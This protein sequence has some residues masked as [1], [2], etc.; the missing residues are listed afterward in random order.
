[1]TAVIHFDPA[2]IHPVIDGVWHRVRIGAIPRPGDRLPM[3]CGVEGVA[4]FDMLAE[5]RAHGVPQECRRCTEVLRQLWGMAPSPIK[6]RP[7]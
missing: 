1:M 3:L 4:A 6:R 7:S 2:T 5:R